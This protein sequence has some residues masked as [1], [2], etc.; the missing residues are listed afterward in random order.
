M[1]ASC[2]SCG[3]T[4][5]QAVAEYY[6]AQVRLPGADPEALAPLAPP[7]RRSVLYG[8]AC[9]TLF[10]LAVLAPGFVPEER[11]IVVLATFLVLGS[12]TF[13]LWLRA[14]KTDRAI[15]A[16][17]QKKRICL[18]CGWKDPGE[19]EGPRSQPPAHRP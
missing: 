7:L 14:R 17:Y 12:A 15:M 4:R 8:T 13:M 11:T 5:L 6:D 18:D 10:F 19:G 2:P 1:P 16:T 3:G 9:A